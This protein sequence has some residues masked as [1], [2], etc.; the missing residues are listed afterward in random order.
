MWGRLD[1]LID[2]PVWVLVHLCCG[3]PKGKIYGEGEDGN[4]EG[5]GDESLGICHTSESTPRI[6]MEVSVRP[7]AKIYMQSPVNLH[8]MN[9]NNACHSRHTNVTHIFCLKIY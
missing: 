9:D 1:L 4:R 6:R 7:H 5:G 3:G 2:H 8:H